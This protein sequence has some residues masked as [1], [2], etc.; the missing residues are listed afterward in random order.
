M[1][2]GESPEQTALREVREELGREAVLLRRLESAVQYFF[3]GDLGIWFRM[4]AHFFIGAFV[5]APVADGEHE[6][7]WIDL[8]SQRGEFFHECHAWAASQPE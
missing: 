5:G 2:A 4:K 6:L 1:H 3:A 8:P 7:H